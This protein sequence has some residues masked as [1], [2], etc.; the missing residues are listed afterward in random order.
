[1]L[2]R[3]LFFVSQCG[4]VADSTLMWYSMEDQAKLSSPLMNRLFF[5]LI[6]SGFALVSRVN[7]DVSLVFNE[8][9]YHPATNEPGLEWVELYNQMSVDVDVSGWFLQDFRFPSNT[10]IR[11]GGFIVVAASPTNLAALT[12]LTNILGPI[13]NRLSNSGD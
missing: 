7:A 3:M 4:R 1:M 10:V 6:F 11:G 9:M 5:L 8:V 13:T 2:G 12:G